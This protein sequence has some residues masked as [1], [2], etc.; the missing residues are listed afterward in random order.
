MEYIDKIGTG[1]MCVRTGSQTTVTVY[2]TIPSTPT[3]SSQ[4]QPFPRVVIPPQQ[5]RIDASAYSIISC[6]LSSLPSSPPPPPAAMFPSACSIQYWLKGDQ[7]QSVTVSLNSREKTSC[8]SAAVS[9]FALTRLAAAWS[10]KGAY[11]GDED[12]EDE[13]EEEEERREEEGD[14]VLLVPVN[15]G[16]A[17]RDKEYARS[18]VASLAEVAL[19]EAALAVCPANARDREKS[20]HERTT[21]A[22]KASCASWLHV[23]QNPLPT[24]SSQPN[25]P[26]LRPGFRKVVTALS[27]ILD[28]SGT[29]GRKRVVSP[30]AMYLHK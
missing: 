29:K 13:V 14:V 27:R 1:R 20:E 24:R 21:R 3:H 9:I 17:A 16:D 8:S 7:L 4:R 15:A 11:H 2:L 22:A 28:I 5:R 18:W 25:Q 10:P 23:P 30:L 19:Y 6:P 12:G 26:T